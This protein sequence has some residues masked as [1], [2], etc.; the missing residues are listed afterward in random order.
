MKRTFFI[1]MFFICFQLYSQDSTLVARHTAAFPYASA[2]PSAKLNLPDQ[3]MLK[4]A[5]RITTGI[6]F[7]TVG[8]LVSFFGP[9]LVSRPQVTHTTTLQQFSADEDTYNKRTRAMLLAGGGLSITGAVF[10]FT[11]A[12]K[13]RKA[14]KQKLN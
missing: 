2:S 1:P 6:I 10:S 7:S 5:N 14:A 8:A 12:R 4:G 11:G 13:I 3:E 9:K